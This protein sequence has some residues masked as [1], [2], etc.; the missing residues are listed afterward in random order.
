MK[1]IAQKLDDILAAL[2]PLKVEWQ[3][4]TARR[5]IAR[6]EKLPRKKIYTT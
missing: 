3:D 5:V 6:L 2:G 4:D 1:V